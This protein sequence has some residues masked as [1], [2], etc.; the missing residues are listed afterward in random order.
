[1][2]SDDI[3][4]NKEKYPIE[5]KKVRDRTKITGSILVQNFTPPEFNKDTTIDK[6]SSQFNVKFLKSL[7]AIA[8][9]KDIKFTNRPKH[10][11]FNKFIREQRRV[12]KIVKS[13]RE[14]TENII[15]GKHT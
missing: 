1:M 11:W 10:S 13:H 4:I 2:I 6:A 7:N 5:T 9:S 3:S 8:P 14:S 12:V 15:N